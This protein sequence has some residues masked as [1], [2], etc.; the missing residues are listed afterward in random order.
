MNAA[1]SLR[2]SALALALLAA[3]GCDRARDEGS[4]SAPPPAPAASQPAS[5][6]AAAPAGPI[7]PP[8]TMAPP[9]DEQRKQGAT[10]A[11]QGAE[12]VA[13]CA[14][15]HGPQGEGNA[16]GGFPR[17]AGQSYAYLLHELESYA[18]GTRKHA[19]MGP[20]A[21]AMKPE[22]RVA[23]AAHYASLAPTAG[24]AP[25]PAAAPANP[26]GRQLA[27]VG[28]ESRGVQACANCHGPG[29]I[30]AGELYP[31]LAGQHATYLVATLGQWRDGSR[32]NDPSG[33]MTLI[34][35]SLEDA[36]I[37]AVA[38]YYAA[39]PPRSTPID[40]ETMRLARPQGA[41]PITSGPDP[42]VAQ[43]AKPAAAGTGTEQGSPQTG[44]SQ[45]P[46]G[47]GATSAPSTGAPAGTTAP[48][49]A[50]PASA[51]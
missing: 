38:N 46:G 37:Q 5:A 21:T 8:A 9:T 29:G 18:Q 13:G 42:Q 48:T 39:Q 35:K 45:G 12:G 41:Q 24:G 30:G 16:A 28:D 23:T 36:D 20:I 3:T 50:S 40:A 26:R 33:Q 44:G 51:R 11:A 25:A 17:I 10:L 15:C 49:P 14:S 27:E 2:W 22:Q 34:G 7:V 31:Y 4:A 47:G 43:A 19:V 6:Q 1:A 32:A